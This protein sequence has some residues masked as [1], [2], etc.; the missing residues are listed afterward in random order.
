[1][2]R[3]KIKRRAGDEAQITAR[4][5]DAAIALRSGIEYHTVMTIRPIIIHPDPRFKKTAAPIAEVTPAIERLAEDMLETMYDAP[6]I[7]LA[8]PQIGV[9]S[10]VFVMDCVKEEGAAPA[11]LVLLNPVITW[12]SEALSTYEE[13]CL[14][15]PEHYGHVERPAEIDMQWM[16]LDGKTHAQRFDGLWATCAQHELDHLNGK[17]FID[18]LKPMRRQLITR[19]MQKFKREQ[20]RS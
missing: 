3:S 6:G 20:A 11:P 17:L 12:V 15:I 9:M 4:I 10:R 1:M 13:G 2:K 18:Y 8:A 7:G 19:K 14:S 5:F 16:G